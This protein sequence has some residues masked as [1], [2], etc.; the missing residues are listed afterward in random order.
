MQVKE[1]KK[2]SE[3]DGQGIKYYMPKHLIFKY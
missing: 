2:N 3:K 1:Y